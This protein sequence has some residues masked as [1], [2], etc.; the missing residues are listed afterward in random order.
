[1]SR[2]TFLAIGL[3]AA[4]ACLAACG[5]QS[6]TP[7]APT[8]PGAT[9]ADGSTLKATAPAPIAPVNDTQVDGTLT[10][11]ASPATLKSGTGTL[12][13][14][15]VV[16]DAAGATVQDSGLVGSPSFTVTAVL[17]FGKRYTW[18]VRAEY[19]N[20]VGPWSAIASFLAPAGGYNR[21]GEL[22]D[23]LING[24][25]VGEIVGPATFIP[26]KGLRLDSTSS[27]VRYLLPETI[28]NGEFSM[29]VQGLTANA[30]GNKS[31]VFGMQE[32]QGDFITNRYRVD[33]QYRGS[34]GSPPNAIT[35]RA[36][37]GSATDLDVRY[38]A[39]TATRLASARVLDPSTTYFW[40]WTWGSAVRLTVQSGGVNGPT[41]YDVGVPAPNG[42]YAPSPHYA[43]LGTPV[44]RSGAESATIPGTIYR[45]V[46]IGN[47]P[48]PR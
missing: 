21:P 24:K 25:T 2:P 27:Y 28:T 5:S 23:P 6:S 32:G 17:E 39:D 48:R 31:K 1:M 36:L 7:V 45:N 41:I 12:S 38:E 26:G 20:A 29:E 30:P 34:S 10:L 44:G 11:T 42:T 14:R 19:D 9:A 47:H 43:Y 8:V 37:Y 15:F 40:K 16:L 13:Y 33:I 46:W 22:F 4:L 18:H 35:F 3:T